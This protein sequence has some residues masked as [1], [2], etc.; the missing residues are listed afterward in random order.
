[1][2]FAEYVAARR[3]SLEKTQKE[4]AE[5]LC[6]TPQA[7][8][9]FEATNSAFPLEQLPVLCRFLDVSTE[10]IFRRN[11]INPRY[12]ER[13]IQ[14]AEIAKNLRKTR[15]DAHLTQESI[16]VLCDT[17][18]RAVRNYEKGSAVPSI[19]LVEKWCE[20]CSVPTSK[21]LHTIR[22]EPVP[23]DTLPR[24]IAAQKAKRRI[25]LFGLP[26]IIVLA[27]S[28]GTA[29]IVTATKGPSSSN[30]LIIHSMG[31]TSQPMSSA[32]Q[33]LISSGTGGSTAYVPSSAPNSSDGEPT[34]EE[35]SEESSESA[36]IHASE[37]SSAYLVTSA[38]VQ[39]VAAV[40]EE[41]LP[42][43]SPNSEPES[44][45]ILPNRVVAKSRLQT[46]RSDSESA[47]QAPGKFE[48]R[49]EADGKA[50]DP[51]DYQSISLSIDSEDGESVSYAWH[52]GE[53]PY[54]EV[55]YDLRVAGLRYI[56]LSLDGVD[57]GNIGY[58]VTYSAGLVDVP[59]ANTT[60][61]WGNLNYGAV[62]NAQ[63]GSDVVT[64]NAVEGASF[65][66]Y[67]Q[68]YR[69]EEKIDTSAMPISLFP[70]CPELP[71]GKK[72]WIAPAGGT[73]IDAIRYHIDEL[74]GNRFRWTLDHLGTERDVLLV[75]TL[76][77]DIPAEG[78]SGR[79]YVLDPMIVHL[80]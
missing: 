72:G 26:I 45:A 44:F 40:S 48:L 24:Q 21:I 52:S 43:F 9:K 70:A 69:G 8:S 27:V 13:E 75:Q 32:S 3:S 36:E 55:T 54:C 67:L 1:M 34:V 6:Y 12:E 7:I 65:E 11:L 66:Y 22:A 28:T 29:A 51:A 76:V 47:E 39:S 4:M 41:S 20:A 15:Q 14:Y 78:I 10:D 53:D 17:S 80:I 25:L 56:N 71:A 64:V 77:T 30:G 68:A 37:G 16:A 63:D 19:Q 61:T 33:P 59:Y 35:S 50:F 18:V 46:V 2:T 5:A 31:S 60:G 73:E 23:D 38:P 62:R 42:D 74:G 79:F 58:L 57:Y 49:L